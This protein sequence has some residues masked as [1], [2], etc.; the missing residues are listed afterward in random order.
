[1]VSVAEQG[2][3]ASVVLRPYVPRLLIQWL[4]EA[5]GTTLREI[6]G[7]VVFV[8]ISG[9]T[10]M[11]ERLARHGKVG[12][13][14]VTDVLAAVF[15]RLLAVAYGNGGGLVKFGGDALLLLFTGDDHQG[16]AARAAIGMRRT[17]R[18]IGSIETSAGKVILRM[19]V[20]I[21][22][23]TFQ[24]FLVG[25]SHRELMVAGPAASRTVLMEST[26]GAGEILVSHD[27]AAALP[28][29]T[30]GQAKG[31]GVLLRREPIGLSL[32]SVETEVPLAGIDVTSSI[33]VGL[34]EHLLSGAIE[35]EHRNV[36]VAFVHFDG[37]DDLIKDQGPDAVAFGLQELMAI[38]QRSA[39]KHSVPILGTDIDHDGGK[40]ILVAGAPQAQGDDEE[41]ML[42]TLRAIL[43]AEP[44]VPVRIGV[45]K[46]PV[47]AG[48][49]GPPFRRTYTVMGD[50]VNLAARVMSMAVPGQIL[51]TGPVL[52]ASTI[53]FNALALEPFMVKGKKDP[54]H[55]FMVG[56]PIGTKPKDVSREFPLVGRDGEMEAIRRALLELRAGAGA[57]RGSVIELVG[58]AGMGKSR[59]LSEFR[60]EAPDLPQ[61]VAGC[62]LYEASVPYRPFRR[63]FRLLL[64]TT[65][66]NDT[67][68]Q[69]DRLRESV[70]GSA[71]E[72]LPWLPL[73]AIVADV[74]VPMTP[75]VADLGEEFKKAKVEEV[76]TEFLARL[77][78]EPTLVAIEDVHWMDE[79]SADLIRH[80]AGRIS[81]L[82]WLVCVT[83]R[84]EETGFVVPEAPRC[85]SLRLAA[86]GEESVS[87]LIGIATEDAPLL[88]H[89]VRELGDL[90]A[91][92]PLFLQELLHAASRA[93]SIH[94]LPDSI[95][96]MVTAQIDRLSGAD[97]RILRYAAVLGTSFDEGL[98]TALLQGEEAATI[99]AGTWWRLRDFV[100]DEGE[101]TYRFHHALMRDA[102]Y[103]GLPY[104]RRRE[105]HARVGA[106]ILAAAEPNVNEQAELLSTH[107]FLAG[108]YE[109]A[110]RFSLIAAERAA[111]VYAN[112]EASR[113][114]RRAIDAARRLGLGVDET[115]RCWEELGDVYERAGLYPDAGRAYAEAR[116][117]SREDPVAGARLMLKR[118]R[119]EDKAGRPSAGLGWLSRAMRALDQVKAAEADVQR[120]RIAS[121][122]AAIR[123]GQGRAKEAIRWGERA[124]REAEAV[125][126]LEAL[127]DAHYMIAWT[128]MNSGEP[129]QG[130]HLQQALELFERTGNLQRQ[131]DVLTVHGAVAYW[132]GNWAEAVDLYQQGKERSV[133]AGDVVGAAVATMNIA[134]IRSDQ[135]RLAEAEGLGREAL[136]V[137]RAAGYPELTAMVTGMLGRMASR[138]R[139]HQDATALLQDGL[140]LAEKAGSHLMAVGILGLIAEDLA[141]RGD[142]V[143]AVERCQEGLDRASQIGGAGVHEPLLHRVR[144]YSLLLLG[145][146]DEAR[147]ALELSLSKAHA[148][149]LTYEVAL[150]V[151]A[152]SELPS[153]EVES[154]DGAA[155][156][157]AA[158]VLG[159]LGIVSVEAVELPIVAEGLA[160]GPGVPEAEVSLLDRDLP[161]AGVQ[162]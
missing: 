118:A 90:S 84:N 129:G 46:G 121:S 120:A 95:D 43:D 139:S 91:G 75:E 74:D 9:F 93:G 49:I 38:V 76:T 58:D 15:S 103:E 127:A 144:G 60:A 23:G 68:V 8:D 106:A 59:L 104:R 53:A 146:V 111:S 61:L 149:N 152:M 50:A 30:L 21:H 141:R 102:A 63:L 45:N 1:V 71:P 79:A 33:P 136:L 154:R 37:I 133:R 117:L 78:G 34:R 126:E 41:R 10:K 161:G 3:E 44:T 16:N 64:G 88:P 94:D 28:A 39:E 128:R 17:L 67:S 162:I 18:E 110:W 24:F 35:P 113:F 87:H 55:A 26:A 145:D 54:V 14:E 153:T 122:I 80:I 123:S 40:I 157:E 70:A 42:L 158:E 148:A 12:A 116:R 143:A 20:G 96:G 29:K 100:A 72:L 119:I 137:F 130:S 107:F 4:D 57:G 13:E 81:D 11:S 47:F 98:L 97:R 86:L 160:F 25:E 56:T 151:R 134:E 36:T 62:E 65:R 135:G 112:L 51:A 22:S 108:Q 77:I 73:I 132:A 92:N 115:V 89:E 7:S 138:M 52:D 105:L 69:A 31:E 156:A 2:L 114:Y 48:D 19:S 99:D 85:T 101:R 131:G 82:R 27:T 83:R 32:D 66:A 147:R 159:R 142:A 140:I 150:T 125:G 109:Q 5:P 155:E 124:I 6:E